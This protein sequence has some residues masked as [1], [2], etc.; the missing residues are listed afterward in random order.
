MLLPNKIAI[1]R[2]ENKVT[3]SPNG[4]KS[5]FFPIFSEFFSLFYLSGIPP[6]LSYNLIMKYMVNHS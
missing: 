5:T 3:L 4:M 6:L 2:V 1:L